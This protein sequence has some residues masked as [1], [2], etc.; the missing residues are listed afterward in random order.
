MSPARRDQRPVTKSVAAVKVRES[1]DAVF[2]TFLVTSAFFCVVLV[3]F[4]EL[5]S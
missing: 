4:E 1:L 5:I 2:V 3:Y